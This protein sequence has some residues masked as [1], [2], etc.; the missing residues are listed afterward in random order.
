MVLP[1]INIFVS[2]NEIRAKI[3]YWQNCLFMIYYN[4]IIFQQNFMNVNHIVKQNPTD[5]PNKRA[6]VF[7]KP[8]K[9]YK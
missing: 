5:K 3:M 8:D 7:F 2:K 9:Y 1:Y 6:R 4:D